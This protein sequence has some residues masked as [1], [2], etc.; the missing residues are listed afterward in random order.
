MNQILA[1]ENTTKRNTKSSKSSGTADVSSIIKFFSIVLIIFGIFM[2][3]TSSFALYKGNNNKKEITQTQPRIELEEKSSGKEVIL[4]IMHD[5]ELESVVYYWNDEEEEKIVG[6][7]R[8]YIEETLHIPSGENTLYVRAYD[9]YGQ[10]SSTDKTFS[11]ESNIDIEIKLSGNN[12]KIEVNSPEEIAYLK[13]YW[14]GEEEDEEKVDV[15]DT[16][17]STEI[18]AIKGE[19]KLTVVAVDVNENEETKVQS[20]VGTTK[21]VVIVNPG[22]NC[23]IIKATDE[24]QL[25]RIE[26][27]TVEDGKVKTY[28]TD[29]KEFECTFALKEN[30]DNRIEITAYNSNGVASDV[31]KARWKK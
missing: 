8:K 4:K 6:K 14:D 19:H 15:N 21:P 31:K 25:D 17:Y 27:K 18:E 26:I 22:D 9:I 16:E 10:E 12:I 11:V 30:N 13:Y 24:I 5:K 2:V 29:T 1:T 3:A 23:Y 28:K 20:V 7:N